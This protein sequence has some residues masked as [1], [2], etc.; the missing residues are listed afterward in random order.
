MA[1]MAGAVQLVLHVIN[2]LLFAVAAVA[3]YR[4]LL[5]VYALPVTAPIGR[6]K[7]DV[8]TEIY[9]FRLLALALCSMGIFLAA[10]FITLQV[11]VVMSTAAHDLHA[12]GGAVDAVRLIAHYLLGM[13][14][15]TNA[16]IGRVLLRWRG[17]L[18]GS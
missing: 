10:L 1:T 7:G 5:D 15:L 2:T 11:D 16:M 17:G 9:T 18:P 13:F 12:A 3:Y 4:L 8:I 14:L 6:R